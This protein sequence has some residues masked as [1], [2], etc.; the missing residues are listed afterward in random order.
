MGGFFSIYM[1]NVLLW[2]KEIIYSYS[3]QVQDFMPNLG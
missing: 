1:I 2:T 3:F